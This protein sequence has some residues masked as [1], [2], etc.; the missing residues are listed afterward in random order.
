LAN[1]LDV[2]ELLIDALPTV[3]SLDRPVEVDDEEDM[4]ELRPAPDPVGHSVGALEAG[5]ADEFR[6]AVDI[7]DVAD[8]AAEREK[9]LGLDV[10]FARQPAVPVLQAVERDAVGGGVFDPGLVAIEEQLVVAGLDDFGVVGEGGFPALLAEV[11]IHLPGDRHHVDAGH[12]PGVDL[13]EAEDVG[14]VVVVAAAELVLVTGVGTGA[15]HAEWPAARGAE[16]P[17]SA[18]GFDRRVD[19]R[20][21]VAELPLPHPRIGR[22]VV[23]ELQFRDADAR[24]DSID[25]AQAHAGDLAGFEDHG[26]RRAVVGDRPDLDLRAV[27]ELQQAGGHVFVLGGPVVDHHLVHG[28]G[29]VPGQRDIRAGDAAPDV[30]VALDEPLV[31]LGD[32][33][34]AVGEHLEVLAV[35]LELGQWG[36]VLGGVSAGVEEKNRRRGSEGEMRGFH[37]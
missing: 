20:D 21:R 5:R 3:H 29:L 16:E 10:R 33:L 25:A 32:S 17:A 14:A 12:Q 30:E 13:G 18:A 8:E 6:L 11:R 23:I 7:A 15:D 28:A 24:A 34:D 19:V 27:A 35:A 22:G 31:A 36:E 4:A 1:S 2:G 37:W 26:S 9:E